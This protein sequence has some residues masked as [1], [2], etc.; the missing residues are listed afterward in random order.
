MKKT[1]L[2]TVVAS[3]LCAM[4]ATALA[5]TYGFDTLTPFTTPPSGYAA[6]QTW[7]GSF[8]VVNNTCCNGTASG[9]YVNNVSPSNE[10][11]D[12]FGLPANLGASGDPTFMLN[13]FYVGAAWNDGENL[14]IVGLLNGVQ[15]GS[16]NTNVTISAIGP[17]ILVT[18]NWSGINE[19]DF[20]PSGGVNHGWSGAGEHFVIDDITTNAVPEPG[21]LMM[22]GSGVVGIAGLLRRKLSL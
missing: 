13:S 4:T 8:S 1:L 15:V 19:V 6:I 9:Y 10:I 3:M 16:Y 17:A 22:L 21:T 11:Y 7:N 20:T 5:G 18:L 2:A 14:N 12:P